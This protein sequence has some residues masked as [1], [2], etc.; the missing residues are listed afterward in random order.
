MSARISLLAWFGVGGVCSEP[1]P[2]SSPGVPE[3]KDLHAPRVGQEPVVEVVV[4]TAQMNPSYAFEFFVGGSCS[5][6]RV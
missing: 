6:V 1:G 4:D 2:S 5:D 3:G